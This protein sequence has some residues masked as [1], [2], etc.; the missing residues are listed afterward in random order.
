MH[1]TPRQKYS[2]YTSLKG[3]SWGKVYPK[4]TNFVIIALAYSCISPLV[5]GLASIG[6]VLFYLSYRHNFFFVVQPKLETNGKCYTRS[7]SQILTGIYVGELAL[8][9]LMALRKATG[10]SV[11]MAIL[12]FG[13][14]IYN[15]F[16]NRFL[17]PLEE[18]L[19]A[20]L[21]SAPNEEEDSLLTAE[22][23]DASLEEAHEQSR[24]H[25]LGHDVHI[26]HRI[27]DPLARFFE[28]QIYAS[29]RVMKSYLRGSDDESPK[30]SDEELSK[31]Y[32]NPSLT[33]NPPKIW[34]PADK[35][36][37]S[38]KEIEAN[39]QADITTTDEGA[40]LDDKGRVCFDRDNLRALPVWKDMIAY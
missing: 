34:L 8:T 31:A 6:L 12:F 27:L 22:E 19:P 38:K 10:P 24:V 16:L 30:Y 13:T 11:L 23:G 15:H 20:K 40:W 32:T 36:G 5:T 37:L 21:L 1:T 18:R 33:S 3:I 2:Q 29:H 25:H 9:G 28:P 39:S 26:P 14:A 7:L 35:A 4:F 17:N